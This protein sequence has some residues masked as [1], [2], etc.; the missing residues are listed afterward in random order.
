MELF[1]SDTVLFIN[2]NYIKNMPTPKFVSLI[3]L[4]QSTNLRVGNRHLT[5]LSGFDTPAPTCWGYPEPK[6]GMAR[7]VRYPG[8]LVPYE[9]DGCFHQSVY[10]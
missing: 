7:A 9:F 2:C 8:S 5:T 6:P 4:N 1:L 3:H 10:L